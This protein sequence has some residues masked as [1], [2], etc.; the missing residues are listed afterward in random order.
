MDDEA[1]W[2]RRFLLVTA[3]RLAGVA[4]IALGLAVGLTNLVAVGGERTIG[5][6]L[7]VIGTIDSAFAPIILKSRWNGSA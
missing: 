5:A 3:A 4:I 2:K 1:M 7:I 6:I